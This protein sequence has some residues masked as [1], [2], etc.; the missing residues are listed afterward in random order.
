MKIFKYILLVMVIYLF[1]GTS[2]LYSGVL[3]KWPIGYKTY[4]K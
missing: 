3:N 1:T 2:L 4:I